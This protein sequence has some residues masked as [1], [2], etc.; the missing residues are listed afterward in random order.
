LLALG[1]KPK[2][3][4]MPTSALKLFSLLAENGKERLASFLSDYRFRLLSVKKNNGI[5]E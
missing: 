3:K 2:Y 1:K 5:D 4:Q